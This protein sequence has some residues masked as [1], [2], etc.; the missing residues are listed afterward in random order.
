M[1]SVYAKSVRN[2]KVCIMLCTEIKL[3]PNIFF[4]VRGEIRAEVENTIFLRWE[5]LSQVLH[6]NSCL[7]SY[8]HSLRRELVGFVRKTKGISVL[9]V[10]P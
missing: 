1:Y 2:S 7:Q 6:D 8:S 5:N 10:S 4:C 3:A 9:S